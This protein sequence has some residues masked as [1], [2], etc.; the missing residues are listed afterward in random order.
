MVYSHIIMM[1]MMIAAITQ[2]NIHILT[3]FYM[4]YIHTYTYKNFKRIA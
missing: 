2:K 1:M 4:I 3:Y